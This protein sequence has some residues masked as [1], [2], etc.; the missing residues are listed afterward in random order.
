[1][2]NA[3]VAKA[4]SLLAASAEK[5][6][7]LSEDVSNLSL[8]SSCLPGNTQECCVKSL[9]IIKV[10]LKHQEEHVYGELGAEK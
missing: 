9:P 6:L 10:V 5:T 8:Q 3:C 7:K 4:N 2:S 1:M